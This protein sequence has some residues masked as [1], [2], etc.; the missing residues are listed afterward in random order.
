MAGDIALRAGQSTDPHREPTM[1]SSTL[2]RTVALSIAA[3]G[4]VLATAS[5]GESFS[6]TGGAG[7]DGGGPTT[8]TTGCTQGAVR[9]CFTGS[10]SARN[11]GLC[12]DGEQT[13]EGG[14]FGACEGEVLPAETDGCDGADNDCDGTIDEDCTCTAAETQSCYGGPAGTQG[15]G[16]CKAGKQVCADGKFGECVGSVVPTGETCDNPGADDDCN[17]KVDDLG[18]C[19]TGLP[20]DCAEGTLHCDGATTV[21]MPKNTGEEVCDGKDNDCDGQVDE[22]FPNLNKS[23]NGS[24]GSSLCTGSIQC[25]GADEKCVLSPSGSPELCGDSKD[26]DCDG[27][28][29]PQPALYFGDMFADNVPQWTLGP[30]W[31][32]GPAKSGITLGVGFN[33]DPLTDHSQSPDNRLAGVV[34]GGDTSTTPHEPWYLTSLAIDLSAA[35]GSVALSYFRWLNSDTQ[36]A[37]VSDIQ[38]WSGSAWLTLWSNADGAVKDNAWKQQSFDITPYKNAAFK[39]R[40]GVTVNEGITPPQPVSSWNIDDVRISSCVGP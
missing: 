31:E 23:C 5:C 15:V 25:V 39:V 29:D 28:V 3:A 33:A 38:V 8:D 37:M 34:L 26:N 24:G 18:P 11:K 35:Q 2:L 6:P 4:A 21:C 17:G 9:P 10:D 12:K 16:T 27:V 40:F 32:I 30:E 7:G 36:P 14:V 19:D 1:S 20:E 13:C 22:T